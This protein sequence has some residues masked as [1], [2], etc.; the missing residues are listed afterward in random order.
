MRSGRPPR[1]LPG[2]EERILD[3]A[4]KVFLDRG[5]KGASIEKNSL[6]QHGRGSQRFRRDSPTNTRCSLAP[7]WDPGLDL[8][9]QRHRALSILQPHSLGAHGRRRLDRVCRSIVTATQDRD[10]QKRTRERPSGG[11]YHG[12]CHRNLLMSTRRSPRIF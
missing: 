2:G 11:E 1:E 9:G 8:A 5:L 10:C 7:S 3:A 6:R 4:R 12:H